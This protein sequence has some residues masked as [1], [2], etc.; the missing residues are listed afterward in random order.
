MNV[1]LFEVVKEE[2][3]SAAKRRCMICA[4]LRKMKARRLCI[5]KTWMREGLRGFTRGGR[6]A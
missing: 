1:L 3:I 2:P 6:T 5:E 4:I